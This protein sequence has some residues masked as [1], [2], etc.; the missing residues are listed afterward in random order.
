MRTQQGTYRLQCALVSTTRQ[1]PC[2]V[3]VKGPANPEAATVPTPKDLSLVS[4]SLQQRSNGVPLTALPQG[5]ALSTLW[6]KSS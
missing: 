6:W 2:A 5:L 3:A 1:S 4:E